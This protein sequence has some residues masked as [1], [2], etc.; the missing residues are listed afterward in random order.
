MKYYSI[1]VWDESLSKLIGKDKVAETSGGPSENDN[2]EEEDEEG[3]DDNTDD[4]MDS[5]VEPDTPTGSP[6]LLVLGDI[7]FKYDPHD[8]AGLKLGNLSTHDATHYHLIKSTCEKAG[9]LQEWK[10]SLNNTVVELSSTLSTQTLTNACSK[11]AAKKILQELQH[12]V[13]LLTFYNSTS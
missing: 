3:D 4:A 12:Y 5:D 13:C 9:Q 8:P 6:A 2:Q 1:V 10:E 11:K 7:D